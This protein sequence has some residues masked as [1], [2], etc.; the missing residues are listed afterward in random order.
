MNAVYPFQ[1]SPR[2]SATSKRTRQP[3]KAPA[4]NGWTVSRF[5]GARGGA[6]AGKRNGMYRHGLQTK[7]A[8]ETRRWISKLQRDA[9]ELVARLDE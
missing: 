1:K 4:V 9:R 5:H 6:P 3:C 2:C 7:E 8:I